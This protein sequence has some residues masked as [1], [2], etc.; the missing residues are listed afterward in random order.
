MSPG[1]LHAFGTLRPPIDPHAL[2]QTIVADPRFRIAVTRPKPKTWWDSL[3]QWLSDRWTQLIDAFAHRVHV[4]ERTSATIGDILILAVIAIVVIAGVRLLLGLLRE[5]APSLTARPLPAHASAQ[6][7]F[8]LGD[9][10]A[11]AGRYAAA[12][13][14]V[15]RAALVELDVQGVVHDDPSRTVNECRG[16]VR[17]RAPECAA[18]F[19]TIARAF[20]DALYADAPVSARQ[21]SAARDAY[22]ALIARTQ[23]DAA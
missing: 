14:L 22:H 9:R 7:L 21:W 4:G 8:A 2:A 6:S 13:A 18:A 17:Q 16:A 11:E 1:G 10:A 3:V 23:S 15:F 19:D 12:I 20:T 5:H